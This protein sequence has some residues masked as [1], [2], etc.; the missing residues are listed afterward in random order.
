[1]ILFEHIVAQLRFMPLEGEQP[2]V[3]LIILK[4]VLTIGIV[5]GLNYRSVLRTLVVLS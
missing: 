1:M 2:I 5:V 3:H 4:R